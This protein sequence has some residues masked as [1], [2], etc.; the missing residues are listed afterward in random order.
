M[1]TRGIIAGSIPEPSKSPHP[2]V[3]AADIAQAAI[4]A[5]RL[6]ERAAKAR[7]FIEQLGL[8]AA[9]PE[10]A[11]AILSLNGGDRVMF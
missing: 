1:P 11:R 3:S 9:T 10:E 2:A 5:G 4:G 6:P 7:R 8:E